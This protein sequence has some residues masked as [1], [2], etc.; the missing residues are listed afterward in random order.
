MVRLIKKML[1]RN[2]TQINYNGDANKCYIS[3]IVPVYNLESVIGR[4]IET[5]QNQSER[6]IE[7]I[8]VDDG[9]T[10]ASR[11]VIQ[12]YL[13]DERI[14]LYEIKHGGVGYA[15]NYGIKKSVGKYLSFIDGDDFIGPNYLKQLL[16][17]A[18]KHDSSLV[19]CGWTVVNQKS[20][21]S[22]E[23]ENDYSRKVDNAIY[24]FASIANNG[25]RIKRGFI[26]NEIYCL[27]N[28]GSWNKLFLREVVF[29]NRIEFPKW[30][31]AED[32][33]F[34][35]EYAKYISSI[36]TISLCDYYYV[37]YLDRMLSDNT[38]CYGFDDLRR[39]LE[40]YYDISQENIALL[41]RFLKKEEVYSF[42]QQHFESSIYSLIVECDVSIFKTKS[43][44]VEYFKTIRENSYISNM[45][46]Q[47][48]TST[49]YYIGLNLFYEKKYEKLGDILFLIQKYWHIKNLM[50]NGI[51]EN[52]A[53]RKIN[54]IFK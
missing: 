50:R 8:V 25:D 43:E 5:I 44:R 52:L 24:N 51:I 11:E 31:T 13:D 33:F 39:S 34:N 4:T 16:E 23:I 27:L 32:A 48:K 40:I 6:N 45:I 54:R 22:S 42:M 36:T 38:R 28:M 21:D 19:C 20:R 15:R 37:K 29:R 2:N 49:W 1:M 47:Y 41:S 7:I 9:S 35:L 12:K 14:S 17:A 18:E 53:R 3:V 26:V 46:A 30:S 10:D